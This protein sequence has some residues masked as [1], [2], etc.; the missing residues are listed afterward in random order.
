[1]S[2]RINKKH[3]M[4]FNNGGV[5]S[6]TTPKDWARGNQQCFPDYNFSDSESTPTIDIIEKYLLE[7][8]RFYQVIDDNIVINY[9]YKAL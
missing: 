3:Y 4:I 2:K 1:M 7:K 9:D 5:I 6:V 8:L